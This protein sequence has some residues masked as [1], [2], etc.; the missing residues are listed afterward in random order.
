MG[1]LKALEILEVE[2]KNLT[3]FLGSDMASDMAK[4]YALRIDEAISELEELENR[5]CEDCKHL[6]NREKNLKHSCLIEVCRTC[7]R[8]NNDNWEQK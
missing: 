4:E 6:A 7:S 2:R 1:N 8:N 5:S 3:R